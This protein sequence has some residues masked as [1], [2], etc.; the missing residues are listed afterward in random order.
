MCWQAPLPGEESGDLTSGRGATGW[1]G[2]VCLAASFFRLT[3]LRSNISCT[4]ACFWNTDS[5]CSCGTKGWW[6]EKIEDFTV[7]RFV[8]LGGN[9][10]YWHSFYKE[11]MC[12]CEIGA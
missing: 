3:R 1:T 4:D 5:T 9:Q 6:G 2:R 7:V 12:F 8:K 11:A 10:V